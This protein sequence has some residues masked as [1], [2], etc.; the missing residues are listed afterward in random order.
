MRKESYEL[1]ELEV[2][3]FKSEDIIITS[4]EE[5]ELGKDSF[6]KLPLI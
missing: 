5:Y 4:G 3:E 1:A 6:I 2:V